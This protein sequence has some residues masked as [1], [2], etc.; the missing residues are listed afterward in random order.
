VWTAK[1]I[2]ALEWELEKPNSQAANCP[3]AYT[4]KIAGIFIRG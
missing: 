2:N 4:I 3:P 1:R